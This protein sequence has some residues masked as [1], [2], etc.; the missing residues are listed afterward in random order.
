[1]LQ[2]LQYRINAAPGTR[3]RVLT[4]EASFLTL[5]MLRTARP[6]IA[7]TGAPDPIFWKTGTSNGYRD[8][9]AIAIFDHYIMAIWV[10]NAGGRGNPAFVGRTCAAPLLFQSI[11]SMRATGRVHLGPHNPPPGANLKRVEF[12]AISGQLAGPLCEHRIEGW[13]IPGISPITSCTVHRNVFI[14][15]ATGMRLPGPDP[16]RDVKKEIY[17]FW[18][19]DLMRLFREAGLPRRRP[20]PFLPGSHADGAGYESGN[21]PR[22]TSPRP[23][24]VYELQAG[25]TGREELTL[26]ARTETDVEQI[27]WFADKQFIGRAAPRN[28]VAWNPAP[29]SYCLTAVD[30]EGRADSENVEIECRLP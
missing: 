13:F 21:A 27:Y 4:P 30:D 10:G 22:I 1:M 28:P 20:P 15:A 7:D 6:E 16:T 18:P 24:T 29:G 19:S 25:A 2:P 8:A 12:C 14:D 23:G 3:R 5:E 26:Q 11:D 17:E 9:W